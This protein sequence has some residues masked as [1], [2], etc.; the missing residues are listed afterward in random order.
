MDSTITRAVATLQAN[1][2]AVGM[3]VLKKAIDIEADSA[4]Q[5]I[6]ASSTNLPANLG[7]NVNTTA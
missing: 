5:L 3:T 2:D 7:R 1:S 6:A 4:M